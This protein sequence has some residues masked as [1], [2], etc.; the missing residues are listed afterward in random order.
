LILDVRSLFELSFISGLIAGS[1]SLIF[2]NLRPQTRLLRHF[3]LALLCLCAAN[4]AVSTRNIAP[5]FVSIILANALAHVAFILLY[6]G[7]HRLDASRPPKRDILGWSIVVADFPLLTW[8]TYYA[9][10]LEF[11]IILISL[12]STF[13]LGRIAWRIMAYSQHNGSLPSITLGALAGFASFMMLFTAVATAIYG[14]QSQSLLLAGP[15]MTVMFSVKPILLLLTIVAVVWLELQLLHTDKQAIASNT[16]KTISAARQTLIAQSQKEIAQ[17]QTG[18]LSIAL[19]DL[20]NFK[21]ISRSHG[22]ETGHELMQWVEDICRRIAR[23]SDIVGR[24][25]IDQIA[26]V[27]PHT[28]PTTALEVAEHLR[29]EIESG[30]CMVNDKAIRTTASIGITHLQPGRTTWNDLVSSAQVAIF[31]ARSSGRNRVESVSQLNQK[32]DITQL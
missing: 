19:I 2:A 26:L 3:G 24:Y 11:R 27:M 22:L 25:S 30:T 29:I 21:V 8:F 16:E 28:H 10:N 9:P 15:P 6:T 1:L 13:L 4:A 23:P 17:S 5:D 32:V 14:E 31:R 18:P 12:A 7:V 20:D